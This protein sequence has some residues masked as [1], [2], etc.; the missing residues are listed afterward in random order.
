MG[1]D[2]NTR[3]LKTGDYVRNIV[4]GK[5]G[6]IGAISPDRKRVTVMTN[7]RIYV[8]WKIENTEL[9]EEEYDTL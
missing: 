8:T 5:H 1:R 9:I 3:S 4:S 2:K 6:I 7:K